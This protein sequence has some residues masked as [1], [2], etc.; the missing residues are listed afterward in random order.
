MT[1]P[2][3]DGPGGPKDSAGDD[4]HPTRQAP[5]TGLRAGAPERPAAPSGVPPRPT[6]LPPPRSTGS[7]P[8]ETVVP[9]GGSPR[10]S[11]ARGLL[12]SP[13]P[14]G[15]PAKARRARLT[16]RRLDPWSVFVMSLL[17]SLFLAVVTIVAA[18]VIYTVMDQLGIPKSINKAVIDVQ[19]GGAVLTRGRF[20][21]GATL[22]AAVDVVLLTAFATLGSFLYNL[23][24]TFSGGLEVTLA[25]RD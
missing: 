20:L 22:L 6:P 12:T 4:D 11:S 23:S 19:G 15:R 17:L 7:A 16:L 21:G 8:T 24:A 14:V 25:E 5:L 18:A 2:S 3:K 9:G 1:A 13:P 10:P